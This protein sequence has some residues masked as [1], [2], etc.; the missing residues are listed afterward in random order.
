M[1]ALRRPRLGISPGTQALAGRDREQDPDSDSPPSVCLEGRPP[2]RAV[3]TRDRAL[4]KFGRF[5]IRTSRP[6]QPGPLRRRP[7]I[8]R[9]NLS[10]PSTAAAA[11]ACSV[12]CQGATNGRWGAATGSVPDRT[13]RL[14]LPVTRLT[15]LSQIFV[16]CPVLS[17]ACAS[18]HINRRLPVPIA[19]L[20]MTTPCTVRSRRHGTGSGARRGDDP[21]SRG[22]SPADAHKTPAQGRRGAMPASLADGPTVLGDRL[23]DHGRR[24]RHRDRRLRLGHIR[25]LSRRRE[26]CDPAGSARAHQLLCVCVCVCVCVLHCREKHLHPWLPATLRTLPLRGCPHAHGRARGDGAARPSGAARARGAAKGPYK[27]TRPGAAA[28]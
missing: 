8:R 18:P 19:A 20:H 14:L 27:G 21:A 1:S 25:I 3:V 24:L 7:R 5:G 10:D 11:A 15:E 9:P 16:T 22:K 13:D 17:H 4:R 28:G 26:R 2:R 6:W 12:K 23:R